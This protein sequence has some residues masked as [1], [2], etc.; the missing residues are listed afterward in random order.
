[1]HNLIRNSLE[2]LEGQDDA[3]V[4]LTTRSVRKKKRSYISI[5]VRDNGPGLPADGREKIF[6]PYVTTKAK[7]TGLG[8]AIVKKLVEEHGGEVRIESEVNAGTTV[9]IL[10]P[11]EKVGEANNAPTGDLRPRRRSA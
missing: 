6:E 11:I 7:G 2:A 3:E 9:K 10:L 4:V 1:L 8:L 5:A